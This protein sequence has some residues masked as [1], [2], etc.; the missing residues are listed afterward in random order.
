MASQRW[1][2]TTS[3]LVSFA[4]LLA[5]F[6]DQS[7]GWMQRP[8]SAF[9]LRIS[10]S[11]CAPVKSRL[12][13]QSTGSVDSVSLKELDNH[14]EDGQKMAKSIAAWLDAEVGEFINLIL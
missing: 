13:L 8:P 10:S 6:A 7:Y 2:I 12:V 3:C 4:F 1:N 11:T 9:V 14:E 5:I